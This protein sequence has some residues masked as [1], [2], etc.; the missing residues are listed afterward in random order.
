MEMINDDLFE[1]LK[2]RGL[3]ITRSEVIT[4][5]VSFLYRVIKKNNFDVNQKVKEFNYPPEWKSI[6]YDELFIVLNKKCDEYEIDMEKLK[7]I[8]NTC[9]KYHYQYKPSIYFEFDLEK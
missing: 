2:S 7:R 5:P 3:N 4:L 1:K 6:G 9:K 8:E